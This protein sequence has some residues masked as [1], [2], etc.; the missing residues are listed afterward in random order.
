MPAANRIRK[1]SSNDRKQEH[2]LAG[3]WFDFGERALFIYTF[4]R[5]KIIYAYAL[6]GFSRFWNIVDKDMGKLLL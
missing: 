2:R 5:K 3:R 6:E 4:A 1:L